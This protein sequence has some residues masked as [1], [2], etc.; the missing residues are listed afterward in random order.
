MR[1]LN[2]YMDHDL[3]LQV[4]SL[5]KKQRLPLSIFVRLLVAENIRA[6]DHAI[7]TVPEN[8]HMNATH[9]GVNTIS[10]PS[11]QSQADA[12]EWVVQSNKLRR[13]A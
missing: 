7:N 11:V 6:K 4:E 5:A 12:G 3:F 13:G 2:V 1:K 9:A 10:I 8:H